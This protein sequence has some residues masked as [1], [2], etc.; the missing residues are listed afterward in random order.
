MKSYVTPNDL[1]AIQNVKGKIL[2]TSSNGIVIVKTVTIYTV[3]IPEEN[4][5]LCNTYSSEEAWKTFIKY[6]EDNQ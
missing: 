2:A 3:W 6:S 5:Q 1:K 4:F